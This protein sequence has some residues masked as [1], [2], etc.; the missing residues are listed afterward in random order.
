MAVESKMFVGTDTRDFNK[1]MKEVVKT[2]NEW[3]RKHL[4]NEVKKLNTTVL[5]FLHCEGGMDKWTNG[6]YTIDTH[7]FDSFNIRFK[8]NGENRSLFVTHSCSSDYSETYVGDKMIFSLGAW[9][10]SDEIML[11]ISEVIK[12][13]GDVYYT[14][15]DCYEDFKKI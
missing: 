3:Q 14:P 5:K 15:N 13:F 2:L 8:I 6:I 4:S 7:D 11:T 1:I 10:M 9:G 12:N